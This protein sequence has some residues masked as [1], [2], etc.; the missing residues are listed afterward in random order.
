M[1]YALTARQ[2]REAEERALAAGGDVSD[3]MRPA[4]TALAGACAERVPEGPVAVLA[5]AGN[6]G[7]DGWTAARVLHQAGRRVHVYCLR[8]PDKLAGAAARA[9]KEAED[10]GV[11]WTA[12]PPGGPAPAELARFSAVVDALLGIGLAGP[13]RAD[14]VPWIETCNGVGTYVV[15]AD[16]PSGVDSD[17]G[18][19]EG[20]AVEADATVTFSAPKVGLVQYPGAGYA[21]EVIVADV[22][23]PRRFLL[24]GG[25]PEI[26]SREE[27][28]SSLPLPAPDDHKNLRGRVL[29]V[30]GSGAYPGAAVLATVGAQ[31]MGAGYVTLACPESAVHSARAHL[32]SAVV[33]GMPENPSHTFTSK[34]A[35]RL[36]DLARD[37]DA[38]V[39]GPGLTV[40][41]GA[42]VVART[43][44]SQ[45]PMPLVID[46]DAL[47]ALV[48][49]T[50]LLAERQAPT[51]MTPHPGEAGRLLGVSTAD[52]QADRLEKARALASGSVTCVLKGAG[53]LIAAGGRL[54][55][56]T[57]GS[58]ALAK[59]GTGDVLAGMI[60]T[61]LAQ[62]L[63]PLEA[64]SLGAY[65]HGR[66]GEAAAEKLTPICV[67]AEDVCE[68]IPEAI[69]DM[70]VDW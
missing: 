52:V 23:V 26:W 24:A 17:R 18:R 57:S 38:V 10:A 8:A 48:D 27:Y 33:V 64:G 69:A 5:G 66:A 56:N 21:G 59:A 68:H 60:G 29:V 1:I 70:L 32:T 37:Y 15:S 61:L 51:V 55:V 49:A 31:R 4:G 22:G 44:A 46:A 2:M 25:A 63:D 41:R 65:V 39:L 62:G 16:V 30:A 58:V 34:D 35:E 54:V 7:G 11:S 42:V 19:V 20:V 40:S 67:R 43:L 53:T 12:G 6:N 36:L 3:L 28:L 13:V 9:A 47:N 50:S 14:L 45:L